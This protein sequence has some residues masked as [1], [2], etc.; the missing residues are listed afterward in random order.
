MQLLSLR[1][2][3]PARSLPVLRCSLLRLAMVLTV[4]LAFFPSAQT[5]CES[6]KR[7]RSCEPLHAKAGMCDAGDT[8]DWRSLRIEGPFLAFV[9]IFFG[10]GAVQFSHTLGGQDSR[11]QKPGVNAHA[12]TRLIHR[13]PVGHA[14]ALLAAVKFD[15]AV[16]PHINVRGT[17]GWN[18]SHLPG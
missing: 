1:S 11:L 6:R 9:E 16:V 2:C 7:C 3:G 14:A 10:V 8:Q 15:R 4:S 17:G 12:V 13:P 18:Q 5:T